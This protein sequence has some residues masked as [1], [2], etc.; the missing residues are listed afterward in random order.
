MSN[1]VEKLPT[2][3]GRA[4][5]LAIAAG[6]CSSRGLSSPSQRINHYHTLIALRSR[7][8]V[9]WD[10]QLTEAGKAMVERLTV[11]PEV[12]HAA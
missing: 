7:G 3:A 11:T 8:L 2:Q 5:L 1:T 6:R 12:R 10:D 4:A 9:T